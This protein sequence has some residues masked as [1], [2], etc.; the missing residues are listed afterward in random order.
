MCGNNLKKKIVRNRPTIKQYEKQSYN[1]FDIANY[2]LMMHT[3]LRCINDSLILK[4]G[5]FFLHK[6]CTYSKC[7]FEVFPI[8]LEHFQFP[9]LLLPLCYISEA[10][11]Y[12]NA[13]ILQL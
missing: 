3:N 2:T 9:V 10:M 13:I 12:F 11:F 7:N 6:F 5:I 4:M 8:L 1:R